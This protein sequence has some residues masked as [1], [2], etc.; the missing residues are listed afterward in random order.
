[1][2]QIA[3]KATKASRFLWLL[4]L[5]CQ[6]LVPIFLQA[7]ELGEQEVR[8]AAKTWVRYVTADA[9]P[10][11]VIERMEPHIVDGAIVAYIAHLADS[12][13]CLCSIDDMLSPVYFYSPARRYDSFDCHYQCILHEI[14]TGLSGL[15]KN[16]PRFQK[17]RPVLE[18]MPP[19]WQELMAG[20]VPQRE[21]PK[22]P[23]EGPDSMSIGGV[24]DWDNW[25]G[26]PA[27][28]KCPFIVN[29][30]ANCT[31]RTVDGC[32][33]HSMSI[34]LRYWK[35][36]PTGEG[37]DQTIYDRRTSGVWIE[38]P[39][40]FYP[41]R[42]GFNPADCLWNGRLTWVA[43]GG[44]KLRMRGDW[45]S[46][47]IKEAKKQVNRSLDTTAYWN[48]LD[49]LWNDLTHVP[50][51]LRANFAATTYQWDLMPHYYGDIDTPD[52]INAVATL[53]HHVGIAC[54]MGY[55]VF[56]SWAGTSPEPY[57]NHFRYD[58]DASWGPNERCEP[59]TCEGAKTMV[60][61][62]QWLRP[63][64]YTYG[65]PLVH[66]WVILGYNRL[67]LPD[68]MQFRGDGGWYTV[69]PVFQEHPFVYRIA[70][71]NV[72]KFVGAPNPG[73]GSPN[74]PYRDIEEAI[75]EAPDNATLIFKA[76]SDNTFSAA[77]LIIDRPF[78]LKGRDVT[79]RK[80]TR[81]IALAEERRR[82]EHER[83]MQEVRSRMHEE[84][85]KERMVLE[86]DKIEG[87]PRK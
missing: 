47:C 68:S 31:L 3:N 19:Y 26:W 16:D 59:D 62:I 45:D 77:P 82:A 63:V 17:L 67:F 44:G 87:R 51:T 80:K 54:H 55:G 36:P 9:R 22:G 57:I 27:N 5:L 52:E 78:T 86:R 29:P 81:Q 15:R 83:G 48:A 42:A 14:A 60:S 18:A 7:R 58:P 25:Q 12:G 70:P 85:E 34:I 75:V 39:L 10:D 79:I 74:D 37:Q 38:T 4:L 76:G 53:T 65:P 35:W 56:S 6:I 2:K 43:T 21:R 61:E 84:A 72:V 11:A 49:I 66:S 32:V 50:D 64:N 69:G 73:D 40:S 33:A 23:W 71:K 28:A 8:A 30:T 1:M 13:F 41:F 24:P 46:E 20:R